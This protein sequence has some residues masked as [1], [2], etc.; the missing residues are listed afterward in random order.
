MNTP[1]IPEVKLYDIL[2]TLVLYLRNREDKNIFAAE[3]LL[4]KIQK[5]CDQYDAQ[6]KRAD[7]KAV[8]PIPPSLT[9]C[10]VCSAPKDYILRWYVDETQTNKLACKI[11]NFSVH[12]VA[13]KSQINSDTLTKLWNSIPKISQLNSPPAP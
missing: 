9:S 2:S 11:C 5:I 7:G 1:K 10:P 13:V 12:L 8:E 6:I 3:R 4:P